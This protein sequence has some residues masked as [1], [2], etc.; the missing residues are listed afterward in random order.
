MRFADGCGNCPQVCSANPQ[1]VS[2]TS[3][4]AKRKAYRNKNIQV[5]APCA[6]M[7]DLAKRSSVWPAGTRFKKIEYGLQLEKFKPVD[8]KAARV[9]LGLDVNKKLIA[10]GAMEID[11]PRKWF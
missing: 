9:E 5:V 11:N 4:L 1:D 8:Q 10:F 2:L 3:L 6:W 7:R